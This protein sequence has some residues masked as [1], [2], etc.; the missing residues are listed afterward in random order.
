MQRFALSTLIATLWS[1]FVIAG[2]STALAPITRC[3]LFLLNYSE[4]WRPAIK[5]SLDGEDFTDIFDNIPG[6]HLLTDNNGKSL[7]IDQAIAD[8]LVHQGLKS[9]SE[10]YQAVKGFYILDPEKKLDFVNNVTERIVNTL[11]S[12]LELND[13]PGILKLARSYGMNSD[14]Y[15]KF[16]AY[17]KKNYEAD[18]FLRELKFAILFQILHK[19]DEAALRIA[20]QRRW[21]KRFS[22]FW[23][24]RKR[25][26][27]SPT[28]L[29]L[30]RETILSSKATLTGSRWLYIKSLK[31]LGQDYFIRNSLHKFNQYDLQEILK[32]LGSN[33]H[34]KTILL[35]E[36]ALADLKLIYEKKQKIDDLQNEITSL[37]QKKSLYT[38]ALS[39]GLDTIDS[40]QKELTQ[41]QW[42]AIEES[43][44]QILRYADYQS[45]NKALSNIF[46]QSLYGQISREQFLK[47]FDITQRIVNRYVHSEPIIAAIY[48][49]RTLAER[50][51]LND[52]DLTKIAKDIAKMANR[53]SDTSQIEEAMKHARTKW[54][55]QEVALNEAKRIAY[56]EDL[57]SLDLKIESLEKELSAQKTALEDL[58]TQY[59]SRNF[60]QETI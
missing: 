4:E 9:S 40:S 55:L 45:C 18:P 30:N 10:I 23:Y 42:A 34:K 11:D 25:P 51:S 54:G 26:H 46:T 19:A 6:L 35:I 36:S 3:D 7:I 44:N 2:D 20:A 52:Q 16:M 29:D 38:N 5:A 49:L 60:S 43:L 50:V 17:W 27:R 12:R 13:L 32:K 1:G 33:L 41:G 22:D 56:L 28:I 37:N 59:L 31:A 21:K 39:S 14:E 53:F 57:R 58:I 47:V 8:E 24:R 15:L 48:Y